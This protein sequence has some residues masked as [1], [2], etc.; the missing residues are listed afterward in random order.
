MLSEPDEAM[1]AVWQQL[2]ECE[3]THLHMAVEMMKKYEK[4]DPVEQFQGEFPDPLILEPSKDYVRKVL[5]EQ[6]HLT[7]DRTEFVPLS[8]AES[9]A[10]YDEYENRVNGGEYV[11][12]QQVIA[13]MIIQD[14]RDY[15]LETNGPHPIELFRD[16]QNLPSRNEIVQFQLSR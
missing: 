16:R 4:I 12:T 1:K 8:R 9:R 2:L 3:I 11:P 13:E 6:F 10:R 15:R 14:N 7:A 5:A